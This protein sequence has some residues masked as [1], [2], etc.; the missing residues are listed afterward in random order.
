MQQDMRG[1]VKR[2]IRTKKR[3][4]N[5]SHFIVIAPHS[6]LPRAGE[7]VPLVAFG[8]VPHPRPRLSAPN[9]Y[10]RAAPCWSAGIEF[11][12]QERRKSSGELSVVSFAVQLLQV[13]SLEQQQHY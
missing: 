10:A 5:V 2:E 7:L 1:R 6:C 9:T 12:Q 3:G 11:Q 8:A 13:G 4:R